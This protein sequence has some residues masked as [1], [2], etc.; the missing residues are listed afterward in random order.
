MEKDYYRYTVT[1][2]LFNTIDGADTLKEIR[3]L[4]RRLKA[5]GDYKDY[6]IFRNDEYTGEWIRELKGV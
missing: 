3:D 4:V 2:G 6:H 5:E 1:N